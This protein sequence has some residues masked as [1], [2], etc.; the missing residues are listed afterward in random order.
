[1]RIHVPVVLE[2]LIKAANPAYTVVHLEKKLYAA[3][4]QGKLAQDI[5]GRVAGFVFFW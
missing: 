3:V 4:C 2:G 5:H 1:M